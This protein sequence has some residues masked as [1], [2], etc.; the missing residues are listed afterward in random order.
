[1]SN[2]IVAKHKCNLVLSLRNAPNQVFDERK[3]LAT[4]HALLLKIMAYQVCFL[5]E[6]NPRVYHWYGWYLSSNTLLLKQ[7]FAQV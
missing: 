3:F 6:V 2:Q 7:L 5:L 1:M 4:Y